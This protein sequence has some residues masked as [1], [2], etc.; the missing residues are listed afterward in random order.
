MTG[1]SEG[2]GREFALQLAQRGFNVV[3]SARNAT[4]LAALVSEIGAYVLTSSQSVELT[5]AST[6]RGQVNRRQEGAGQGGPD[7][8]LQ[9]R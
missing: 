5:R 8:F 1:A 7:G 3:V 6:F 9:A 4:A 2:I